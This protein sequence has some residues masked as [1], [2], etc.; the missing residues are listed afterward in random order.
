MQKWQEGLI[1]P[2]VGSADSPEGRGTEAPCE[3]G[4]EFEMGGN[5]NFKTDGYVL[6]VSIS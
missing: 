3:F 6:R 1:W 2:P 4:G 5:V